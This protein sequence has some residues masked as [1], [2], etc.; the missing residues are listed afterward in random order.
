M[1]I[2]LKKILKYIVEFRDRIF[3]FI[4][5]QTIYYIYEY[6]RICLF[7]LILWFIFI[8]FSVLFTVTNWLLYINWLLLTLYLFFTR[9]K[10]VEIKNSIFLYYAIV[11]FWLNLSFMSFIH[12]DNLILCMITISKIFVVK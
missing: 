11:F 8:N 2:F 4:F 12:Y 6:E 1:Y 9:I 7:F 5:G 3:N 10:L